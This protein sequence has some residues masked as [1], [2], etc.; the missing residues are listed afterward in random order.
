MPTAGETAQLARV[1]LA[2]DYTEDELVRFDALLARQNAAGAKPT[3]WEGWPAFIALGFAVAIGATL[4]AIAG[5]AVTA[6]SGAGIATLAFAAYW[7][8]ITAPGLVAGI[9]AKRQQ[10]ATYDTFR[11]EWNGTR[12]LATQGGIWCRREGL[13]SFIG[14]SAIHKASSAD[15][16]LLLHLR[17]GQPI[18]L[19]ER[20]LTPAQQE[21]LAALAS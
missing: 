21:F 9:A 7:I 16:L 5:G 11:E 10:Q 8:G 3:I 17:A 13:R 18:M 19:P 15:G 4:L 2:L 20:L 12:L 1:E 6:R 14:R